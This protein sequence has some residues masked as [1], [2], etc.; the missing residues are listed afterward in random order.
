VLEDL[1][2]AVARGAPIH[3]EISGVAQGSDAHNI[4]APS[5]DG[6]AWCIQRAIDAAGVG[7]S[8]VGCV[9]AH[10][11]GTLL[12]DRTESKALSEV[13]GAHARKLVV[14][15]IK[16]AIGHTMGA[17]GSLQLVALLRALQDQRVPPTLHSR[18]RDP[19]CPLDH[20]FEGSRDMRLKVGMSNS[21][22]FGGHNVSIVARRFS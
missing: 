22:A 12:N 6:Q 2:H 4:V 15:A 5:V 21:F 20:V 14:P 9:F 17:S 1:E 13:F 11:T 19:E 10:G 18:E 7:A 3:G 16:G 8:E